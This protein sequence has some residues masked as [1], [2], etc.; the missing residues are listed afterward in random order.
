MARP[1][2]S[3]AHRTK[4]G[5]LAAALLLIAA[6]AVWY[7]G[8]PAWT[9]KGMRDAARANDADALNSYVDY[10][11]L[12]ASVKSQVMAQMVADARKDQ[13]G[14]GELGIAIGSAMM[15]PLID[16]IVSPAG[17]R[18]ALIAN[19]NRESSTP[20]ASPLRVPDQPVIVRR[21][22][23]EF[24]VTNKDKRKGG[25]VFKRHGLSWK[26]SGVALPPT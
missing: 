16:R 3:R 2:N 6:G 25:L 18:T 4:I 11:A 15:S 17:V 24:V 20:P 5:A 1:S 19:R 22:F 23:S 8:S 13:S 21:G 7:L 9:L 10:P 26:L 12:R 14:L